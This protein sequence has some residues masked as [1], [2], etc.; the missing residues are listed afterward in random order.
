MVILPYVEGGLRPE[1]RREVL[2]QAPAAELIELPR[3]DPL[4]YAELLRRRW[5]EP[6]DLVVVE[7]DV[8]PPPGGIAAL[9][10]CPRPWC[11]FP[12]W[13]EDRYHSGTLQLAKFSQLLRL[14]HPHV[15]DY[16]LAPSGWWRERPALRAGEVDP[17]PED[18]P[19]LWP[20]VVGYLTADSALR[21]RLAR[22]GVL[23]CEHGPDPVHLH[24]YGPKHPPQPLPS[25][26]RGRF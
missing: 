24:D 3:N 17:W 12:G 23:I 1:T 5:R 22:S 26:A 7:Q 9:L 21:S 8:V 6:G 13:I 14:R 16:A 15:A 4:A 2:A 20:T 19:E 25:W 10:S 11:S 18:H